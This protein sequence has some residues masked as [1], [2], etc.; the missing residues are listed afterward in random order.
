RRQRHRDHRHARAGDA[1][2]R[3]PDA[4]LAAGRGH[5]G[6]VPRTRR[7][8]LMAVPLKTRIML[9]DDH[10]VVRGGLRMVLDA[11]PDLEVVCEAS[12]GAEALE[13]G[14]REDIDLA[15]LDVSMPKMTG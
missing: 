11:E 5:R 4:A 7:E 10:A 9:A 14:L 8:R 6:R 2:R 13:M 12:D 1:R 15:V 3:T